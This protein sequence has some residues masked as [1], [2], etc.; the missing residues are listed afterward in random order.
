MT[1]KELLAIVEG[2]L[3][4]QQIT[5]CSDRKNLMQDALRPT[6][7]QVYHWRLLL[8]EHGPTIMYINGIHNTVVDAISGL[9]YGPIPDN[10]STWMIFAQCWCYH[11][12]AQEHNE[13]MATIK[14]SINFVFAN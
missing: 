11:N 10:R 5:V 2:M 12:S 13:S 1:K 3:W 14:E 7:V 4:G 8:E 9:D 6:S